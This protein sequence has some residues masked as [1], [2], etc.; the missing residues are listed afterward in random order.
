MLAAAASPRTRELGCLEQGDGMR[1]HDV[2]LGRTIAVVFDHGEDFYAA[3]DQA[4]RTHGIR[5]GLHPHVHRRPGLRR[6]RRHL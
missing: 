4:C 5:Q 2:T 1:S 3:L 6:H